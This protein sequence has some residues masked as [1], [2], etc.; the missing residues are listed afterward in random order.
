MSNDVP[1]KIHALVPLLG[2]G[3]SIAG[4]LTGAYGLATSEVGKKHPV[5]VRVGIAAAIFGLGFLL[6]RE[7][8]RETKPEKV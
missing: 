5:V 2:A 6:Y 3:A 8:L 4:I 1:S 7:V